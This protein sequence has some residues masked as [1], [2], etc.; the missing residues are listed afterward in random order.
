MLFISLKAGSFDKN[1]I[2]VVK[3]F[4]EVE[5][6]HKAQSDETVM[7]DWRMFGGHTFQS[8]SCLHKYIIQFL[9]QT[10]SRHITSV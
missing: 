10:N 7:M 3:I 5:V 8:C 2:V 9:S 4:P 1:N 6:I